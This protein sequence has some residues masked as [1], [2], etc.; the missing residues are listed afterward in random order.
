MTDLVLL[1]YYYLLYS[2]SWFLAGFLCKCSLDFSSILLEYKV[3][4]VDV[5]S[6]HCLSKVLKHVQSLLP[7]HNYYAV[8]IL[9]L[10]VL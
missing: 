4:T 9:I 6:V 10:L 1:R 7:E 8:I 2:G 3:H 5:L